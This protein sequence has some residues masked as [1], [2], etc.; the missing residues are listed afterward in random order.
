MGKA[1]KDAKSL[2]PIS[3]GAESDAMHKILVKCVK[4]LSKVGP[5]HDYWVDFCSLYGHINEMMIDEKKIPAILDPAKYTS[6]YLIKFIKSVQAFADFDVDDTN[7]GELMSGMTLDPN[8]PFLDSQFFGT[9]T[10]ESAATG[11]DAVMRYVPPYFDNPSDESFYMEMRHW[12]STLPD[13][14]MIPK[15]RI[16]G[17]AE[18]LNLPEDLYAKY[19]RLDAITFKHDPDWG[20]ESTRVFSN[21][22]FCFFLMFWRH[23]PE[24]RDA[25]GEDTPLS[26]MHA[27]PPFQEYKYLESC[28]RHLPSKNEEDED[29][30]LS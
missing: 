12:L 26:S 17:V 27:C 19:E 11:S 16:A 5:V 7:T 23:P 20:P 21:E 1:P 30:P 6:S 2:Q 14:D 9:S 24:P 28:A 8:H 13:D 29:T 4:D 10:T 3:A 15:F 22:G 25:V 18:A